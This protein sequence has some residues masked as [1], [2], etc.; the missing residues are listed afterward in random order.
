MTLA[1]RFF[2]LLTAVGC[3]GQAPPAS[4]ATSASP[5][6][7]SP[8]SV[9]VVPFRTQWLQPAT[10]EFPHYPTGPRNAGVEARVVAAFVINQRGQVELPTIS[11]IDVGVE[12]DFHDAVCEFLRR[13]VFRWTSHAPAR[14]LVMMPFDFTLG[15]T[16]ITKSLPPMPDLKSTTA[17]LGAYSPQQLVDWLQARPH[18]H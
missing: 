2:I 10:A 18:C 11:F 14:G 6:L 3:A 1:R 5:R 4:G 15:N 16:R 13:A 12:S 7:V 9:I 17:E 8:E